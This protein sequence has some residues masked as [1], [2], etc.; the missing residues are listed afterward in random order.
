MSTS[1]I[2]LCSECGGQLCARCKRRLPDG[3]ECLCDC[4]CGAPNGA[5]HLGACPVALRERMQNQPE[6]EGIRI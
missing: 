6:S 1:N 4:T 5:R 2:V 3:Y